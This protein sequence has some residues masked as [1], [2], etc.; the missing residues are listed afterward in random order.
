MGNAH[1]MS[2]PMISNDRPHQSFGYLAPIGYAEKELAKIRNAVLP[3]G[4]VTTPIDFC[5][6]Y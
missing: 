2:S 1:G 6:P 3:T 5:C 4:S